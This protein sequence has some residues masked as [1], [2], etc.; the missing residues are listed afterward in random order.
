MVHEEI[1]LGTNG[2]YGPCDFSRPSVV[3][4]DDALSHVSHSSG[5]A[6]D[7][8]LYPEHFAPHLPHHPPHHPPHHLP[9]DAP[10]RA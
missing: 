4:D 6:T 10:Q 2:T 1:Q 3:V 7:A 8:P 5:A 9:H